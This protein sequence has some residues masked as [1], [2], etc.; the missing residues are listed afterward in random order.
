MV[1]R[2]VNQLYFPPDP[3]DRKAELSD[4]SAVLE[5]FKFI[6]NAAAEFSDEDEDEDGGEGRDRPNVESR[7]VRECF[8]WRALSIFLVLLFSATNDRCVCLQILRKKSSSSSSS[9]TTTPASMD[10]SE[11]PD[12]EEA[13]KGFDFLSSPDEMDTSPESRGNGDGT[14]WGKILLT[15]SSS[16]K[17]L[18]QGRRRC[19][20]DVCRRR[21]VI[22]Q[23]TVS[24][25]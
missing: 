6:E 10:T 1:N 5:A 13:L 14:D 19:E 4:T 9:S 11:D 8:L 22:H 21:R 18:P 15:V 25:S 16:L 17:S 3:P 23:F 12:T 20:I 24:W 7:T 2:N